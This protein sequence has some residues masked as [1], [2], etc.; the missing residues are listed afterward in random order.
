MNPLYVARGVCSREREGE[1][2]CSLFCSLLALLAC[3]RS[4]GKIPHCHDKAVVT[5]S[6]YSIT[7]ESA[8]PSSCSAFSAHSSTQEGTR[9]A[10]ACFGSRGDVQPHVAFAVEVRPHSVGALDDEQCTPYCNPHPNPYPSQ[11]TL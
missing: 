11:H 9:F 5:Y 4:C 10:Y 6:T 1:R 3:S 2:G 7:R 8:M